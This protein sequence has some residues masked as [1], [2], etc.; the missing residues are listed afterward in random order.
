MPERITPYREGGDIREPR[1]DRFYTNCHGCGH[2]WIAAHLPME[3]GRIAKLMKGLRCPACG[4]NSKAIFM[5]SK[6]QAAA[7]ANQ[8][9]EP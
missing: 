2:T 1:S 4:G 3:M 7:L 5:A 8:P 6:A 9:G